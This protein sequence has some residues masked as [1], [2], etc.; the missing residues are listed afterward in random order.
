MRSL[1]PSSDHMTVPVTRAHPFWAQGGAVS[2]V[3][4]SRTSASL[5]VGLLLA[6]RPLVA[7]TASLACPPLPSLSRA[8]SLSCHIRREPDVLFSDMGRTS[9]RH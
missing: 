7:L 5:R 3:I 1:T 2:Q 9:S 6:L 4:G 8:S